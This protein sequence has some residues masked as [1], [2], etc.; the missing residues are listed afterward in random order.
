MKART[1]NGTVI[2][3]VTL[4]GDIGFGLYRVVTDC[5]IELERYV[6]VVT[7]QATCKGCQKAKQK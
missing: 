6:E 3:S 5:G 2:H 4:V 7:K 1:W